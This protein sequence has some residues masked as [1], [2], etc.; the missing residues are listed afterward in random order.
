MK[1]DIGSWID[2]NYT[3]SIIIIWQII[4]KYILFCGK[5]KNETKIIIF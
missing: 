4:G 5:L 2:I 1:N 3:F